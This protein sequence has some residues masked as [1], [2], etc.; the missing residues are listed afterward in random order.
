MGTGLGGPALAEQ[1]R[2][3]RLA[4][5]V[6]LAATRC[7]ISWHGPARFAAGM[8]GSEATVQARCGLMG[9]N[10]LDAGRPR[11]IGLEIASV[12]A[13]VLAAQ[14]DLANLI[15]ERRGRDA[16]PLETSVLQAGLLLLSHYVAAA[17]AGGE[18]IPTSPGPAPGPP[19]G[20]ADGRWFEIEVFDPEA[21][22]GFWLDLGAGDT[23]LGRSWTSFRGRYYRGDCS[24]PPG[25]HEATRRHT[26]S[27]V[28]EAA[29]ARRVSLAPL[30]DYHEVRTEPGWSDGH[31]AVSEPSGGTGTSG[32]TGEAPRGAPD[33]DLPLAGLRL[34]EATN[35]MQGPLAGHLLR[36][37]GAEVVKVEPP[38]GDVGRMVPP[39]AGDTGSFFLCFNRGKT[40][41]ELDLTQATGRAELL[42]L[43]GGADAFLH[44]WRPGK[45]A[46]WRLDAADLVSSHP[47]LVHVTASGWGELPQNRRLIGTDFLVQAYT[48]AGYGLTPE[49]ADSG[50]QP[51]PRPPR[52]SRVLLT[53]FMGALITC[54]GIL[55]GLYRREE[56]GGGVAV[57]T[58]LVQ[59][60]MAVQAHVFA[61]M[62]EGRED[63]RHE[64][65]PTWGPLDLP[66]QTSDGVLVVTADEDAVFRRL[67]DV[68]EVDAGE[69]PRA[70]VERVVFGRIRSGSAETWRKL[71]D[72]AGVPCAVACT[73]LTALPADPAMADLFEPLSE[74]CRAPASP[75]RV[76]Q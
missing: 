59:G 54:E 70:D 36:L 56:T 66:V 58:S 7:A 42:E 48:G 43:L 75:W 41:A 39:Y 6:D 23:D 19:F 74:T 8:P 18:Q 28:T 45:A 29:V 72:D 67:C 16:V 15:A 65:R 31:P 71:L 17:T 32:P 44:N 73:D 60:A 46:E 9:V 40:T 76:R 25:L 24:F 61:G 12:A 64:G 55:T 20:T 27:E 1:T 49:L 53:D 52:T 47:N 38:G 5:S 57:A 69:G 21:W 11:R 68:C 34:V 33:A 4:P 30:R 13:G 2:A 35:R 22:R 14:G 62:Q 51:R 37:L 10:G 63:G 26:L 3:R 50:G